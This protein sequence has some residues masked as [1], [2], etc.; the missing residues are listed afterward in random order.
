MRRFRSTTVVLGGMGVL[1]A[2][3][4]ACSSEPDRR[5][6]DPVSRQELP[7]YECKSG[8]NGSYYYGGYTRNGIVYGGSFNR[9]GSGSSTSAGTSAGTSSGTSGSASSSG[10]SGG[11]DRGGFG[12]HSGS[13]GG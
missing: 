11:V 9:S 8:G 2:T 5:C 3:L 13:S 4:T 6:V 12:G 10:S 1:A 7:K